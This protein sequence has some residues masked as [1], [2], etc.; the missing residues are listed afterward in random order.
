M[1]YGMDGGGF[2]YPHSNLYDSD[3][4]EVLRLYSAL[5][6]NYNEIVEKLRKAESDWNYAIEFVTTQERKFLDQMTKLSVD[7]QNHMNTIKQLENQLYD[8]IR[9]EIQRQEERNQQLKADIEAL[10]EATFEKVHN[11]IIKAIAEWTVLYEHYNQVQQTN[12][13][14]FKMQFETDIDGLNADI[15]ENLDEFQKNINFE[16]VTLRSTIKTYQYIVGQFN[17][18]SEERYN[19]VLDIYEKKLQDFKREIQRAVNLEVSV[20]TS[21]SL[22]AVAELKKDIDS[23]VEQLRKGIKDAEQI[24][25]VR[26]AEKFLVVS[27]V[28]KQLIR[29]QRVLN[30]MW[31]SFK[32]WAIECE[33]FDRLGITCEQF[34]NW[35]CNPGILPH[36][37]GIEALQFDCISRWIL[38]EK[39]DILAQLQAQ[40][41][42]IT[43]AA[44]MKSE[45]K[46]VDSA[47]A[48]TESYFQD[49]IRTVTYVAGRLEPIEGSVSTLRY[50]V[51]VLENAVL[52]TQAEIIDMQNKVIGGMT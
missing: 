51:D 34:D 45:D 18:S 42:A 3:L 5:V 7:L 39:P 41:Q 12:L 50:R 19:N 29:I 32:V 52:T 44:I 8:K 22:A 24:N 21:E 20:G 13:E 6:N 36:K 31:A 28:T 48:R 33:E 46:V 14:K 10:N 49:I 47:I 23:T 37:K 11:R 9:T 4:S 1:A 35:V 15:K 43:D 16:L 38:L 40:I 26:Q 17:E 27:P 25:I 2:E 30:E